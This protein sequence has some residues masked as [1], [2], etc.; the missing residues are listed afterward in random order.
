MSCIDLSRPIAS[1]KRRS[2]QP[3]WY[4]VFIYKCPVGHRVAVRA[5]AFRGKTPEPGR[6]AITCPQ[7]DQH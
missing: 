2:F 6:G 3:P 5:C 1:E 7:C 4:T